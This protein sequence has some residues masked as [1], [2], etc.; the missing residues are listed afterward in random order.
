[1]RA[2]DL[3]D[4]E[5]AAVRRALGYLC[6]R[7]GSWSALARVLRAALATVAEAG[8]GR[9]AVSASLAFRVARVAAVP[10][11]DVVSGAYPPAGACPRCGYA[12]EDLTSESHADPRLIE[13][14]AA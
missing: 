6:V 11:G 7:A 9:R 8:A 12:E 13:H 5:Q 1:V 10:V 14:E 3:T 2:S 4:A